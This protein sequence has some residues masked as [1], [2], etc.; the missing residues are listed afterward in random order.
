MKRILYTVA[1]TALFALPVVVLHAQIA[2]S[3]GG[4]GEFEILL[5]NILRFTNTI[6]IPFIIGIGFLVFVW[7]MFRYFIAG[8]ADEAKRE[9]GK[10]LMIYATLGFVL[11][12]IFWG[13]INFVVSSIGL[14]NENIDPLIPKVKTI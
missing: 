8:G 14:E 13:V 12:I 7:G 3:G 10:Q 9:S 4:G 11:I 5:Q 1:S 2:E 6:L